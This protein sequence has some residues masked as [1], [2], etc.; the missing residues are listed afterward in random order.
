MICYDGDF[1]E[2]TRAYA[3]MGCAIC[4]AEQQE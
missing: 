4:S 1:P 2:M 3:N